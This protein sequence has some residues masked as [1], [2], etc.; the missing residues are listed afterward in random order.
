MYPIPL[1]YIIETLQRCKINKGDHVLI[2][3]SFRSLFKGWKT[4][5]MRY[6]D[7]KEYAKDLLIEIKNYLDPGCILIP[8]EFVGDY[9]FE[10]FENKI[11]NPFAATSNRGFLT[12]AFL[13]LPGV[14]RTLHPI[15]NLAVYGNHFDTEIENHHNLQFTMQKGSPWY[16]FTMEQ[17]KIIYLGVGLHANS[18]IHLPEYELGLEYPRPVFFHKPHKFLVAKTPEEILEIYAYV[19]AIRWKA[20]TVPMFMSYLD[21]KYQLLNYQKLNQT[22]ITVVNA[23]S[24]YNALMK[25][26]HNNSSWYDAIG[27]QNK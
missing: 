23:L 17:G 1:D 8:T 19:H 4:N 7:G 18:L 15:Y 2:H 20:E 27:W 21:S 5:E 26:L 25:E 24:Q 6:S 22:E 3:S 14:K 10:S 9:H 16:K 11:F 12:N 13:E